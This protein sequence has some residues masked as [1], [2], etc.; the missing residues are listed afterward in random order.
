M[1]HFGY[2]VATNYERTSK[3]KSL[4]QRKQ[5]L[6]ADIAPTPNPYYRESIESRFKEDGQQEKIMFG[7]WGAVILGSVGFLVYYFL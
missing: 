1:S 6:E 2:K 5:D 3:N 7:I 4:Y